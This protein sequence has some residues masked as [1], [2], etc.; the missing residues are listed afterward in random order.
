M[1]LLRLQGQ[2]NGLGTWGWGWGEG[3]RVFGYPV[4]ALYRYV[5]IFVQ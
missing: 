4:Q 3:Y 5:V 2:G 1:G